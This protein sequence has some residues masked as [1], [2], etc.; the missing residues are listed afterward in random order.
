MDNFKSIIRDT[1]G[2]IGVMPVITLI[3]FQDTSSISFDKP[4]TI[5]YIGKILVTQNFIVK[6]GVF[7]YN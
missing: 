2:W 4:Q 1:D 5:E 7:L 6:I 3:D